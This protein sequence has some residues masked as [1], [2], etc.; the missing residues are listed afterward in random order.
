MRSTESNGGGSL[1]VLVVGGGQAG[2]AA[3][4]YLRRTGLS[5]AILD[6]AEGPGGAWRQGWDSLRAFSPARYSSLPGR[7]MPGGA[8]DYPTRDEVVGYLADY[9]GRYALPVRRSVRVGAV[10][11]RGELLAARVGSALVKARAVVSATGTWSEP[12][13]PGYPGRDLFRGWQVHSAFYRSPEPYRGKKVLVVGGGNSAAQVLAEVSRVAAG[14]AWATL[15]EP[16]FLPDGVG[17]REVFERGTERYKALIES[18]EEP[19]A[20]PE[21][22]GLEDIVVVPPV[23]EA[24][25]RGVLRSVGPFERLAEG[26]IVWPDGSEEPFDA[27]IWCTGFRPALDHLCPLGVVRE[28]GRVEVEEGGVG[29]RSVAEPRLWLVGYG[30]W[31]GFASATLIGVGRSARATVEEIAETLREEDARSVAPPKQGIAR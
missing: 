19:P 13:V 14:T 2:L 5:F 23:E 3:G 31:T 10:E 1:D 27:V 20:D 7:M 4:Y 22:G 24:R 11:R 8:A 6:A 16:R 26:G 12:F 21:A 18:R 30:E 29:T 28:D 25:G 9:E 15:G 17:V